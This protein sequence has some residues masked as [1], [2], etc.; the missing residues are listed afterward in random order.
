MNK[1]AREQEF[2]AVIY[3]QDEAIF[4]PDCFI[5][6]MPDMDDVDLKLNEPTLEQQSNKNKTCINGHYA[7]YWMYKML[8]EKMKIKMF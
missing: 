1:T 8:R 3:G 4:L 7:E 5:A 6:Q 2:P